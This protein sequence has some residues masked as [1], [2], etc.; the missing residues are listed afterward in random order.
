MALDGHQIRLEVPSSFD[1][2]DLVQVLSDR[3]SV[4]AGLDEDTIH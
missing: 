4:L 2:L 3:L 1:I